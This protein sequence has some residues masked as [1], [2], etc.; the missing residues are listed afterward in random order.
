MRIS[1]GILDTLYEI[2]LEDIQTV[3]AALKDAHT[4]LVELLPEN[5]CKN[6]LFVRKSDEYAREGAVIAFL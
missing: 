4:T 5:E 6:T 3:C 1:S 2:T